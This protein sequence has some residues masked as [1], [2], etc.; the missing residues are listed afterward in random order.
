MKSS[1]QI[2]GTSLSNPVNYYHSVPSSAV[3]SIAQQDNDEKLDSSSVKINKTAS[4]KN[5][6]ALKV[7]TMTVGKFGNLGPVNTIPAITTSTNIRAKTFT[8]NTGLPNN[9]PVI[10]AMTEFRPIFSGDKK[11]GNKNTRNELGKILSLKETAGLANAK[12]AIALLSQSEDTKEVIKNSKSSLEI[13]AQAEDRNIVQLMKEMDGALKSLEVTGHKLNVKDYFSNSVKSIYDILIKGG[14][15][16]KEISTFTETKMWQ[17][18]LVEVKKTL[19]THTPDLLQQKFVRTPS[20]DEKSPF[21][22]SDVD[23][24]PVNA[25]NLW[26]NTSYD[27][28]PTLAMVTNKQ[29]VVSNNVNLQNFQAKQFINFSNANAPIKISK[30]S[31]TA[32][33]GQNAKNILPKFQGKESGSPSVFGN[34]VLAPHASSGRDISILAHILRREATYSSVLLDDDSAAAISKRFGYTIDPEGNNMKVWDYMIGKF[35]KSVLDFIETPQ[36]NGNSLVSLSQRVVK[37][38]QDSYNVLTFE[39]N[40]IENQN[41]TPGTFYYVD[42]AINT[43]D[44]ANFDTT[45]LEKLISDVSN[46]HNTTTMMLEMLGVESATE[47]NDSGGSVENYK[48]KKTNETISLEALVKSL[49]VVT[50]TYE[51]FMEVSGDRIKSLLSTASQDADLATNRLAA[52]ICKTAVQPTNL[53]KSKSQALKAN[54]FLWLLNTAMQQSE[55]V[56]NSETI[57]TYRASIA[58]LLTYDQSLK[59]K[60]PQL[61]NSAYSD[62]RVYATSVRNISDAATQVDFGVNLFE[63]NGFSLYQELFFAKLEQ[64]LNEEQQAAEAERKKAFQEYQDSITNRIFKLE[65]KKGLWNVIVTLL[66][67]VYDSPNIFTQKDVTAY[68][69][70]NRIAYLY[71]YFDLILRIIAAQ[72]PENLTGVYT[73][74]IDKPID[75]KVLLLPETAAAAN[76]ILN[77]FGYSI[78]SKIVEEGITQDRAPLE[79]QETG[80][81]LEKTSESQLNSYFDQTKMKSFFSVRRLT[82]AV[83]YADAEESFAIREVAI[84][85]SYLAQL[86]KTLI[87]Y[88]SYLTHNFEKYLA[89]IKNLFASDS[90]LNQNQKNALTNLSV[91]EEQLKL[92]RYVMSEYIDRLKTDDATSKLNSL[93]VFKAFPEGYY[94]FL[95]MS[96]LDHISY[97]ILSPYFSGNEFLNTKGNNKKIVSVGI[98][99]KMIKTLNTMVREGNEVSKGLQQGIIRLKVWKLDKLHP[100]VVYTPVS[101]LFETNRFP[102]RSMGN[103]NYQ[104]IS[105]ATSNL[106]E[107]PTKVLY[108]DGKIVLN[109][110]FREAFPA[111]DYGNY[112]KPQEKLE[113]YSN[114]AM[115]FLLEQYLK[116]FTDLNF[117]ETRYHNFSALSP[118]MKAVKSQYDKYVS[119]VLK[120]FKKSQAT[121]EPVPDNSKPSS[122]YKSSKP[123]QK[124]KILGSLSKAKTAVSVATQKVITQSTVD[125]LKKNKPKDKYVIPMDDTIEKFFENETFMT[126]MDDF[127]KRI[128]YPKKFDRV[129]NIIVDPDDFYVDVSMT[130]RDVIDALV[131]EKV[132][133]TVKSG[134]TGGYKHRD[135]T[136]EDAWLEEYFV[137]IEPFDY[138]PEYEV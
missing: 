113:I 104:A 53:Y 112:L 87:S 37:S 107:I 64:E 38:G 63:Q 72:T 7:P 102:T 44:G 49:Y 103:W 55:G 62:G 5:L 110:E 8:L 121:P 1:K 23:D 128:L 12:A 88:R 98:P 11:V 66:K 21:R 15:T 120:D 57:K 133:S 115:S 27:N 50:K 123:T 117:E 116:W 97:T 134:K 75:P 100:D 35:P 13:F 67:E 24:P 73:K 30:P 46:A 47:V 59:I 125:N 28:L 127:K 70:I 101:Y 99:Q 77:D 80:L 137:T 105:T 126:D 32:T 83:S 16:S 81:M 111:S 51:K 17:Q 122:G 43:P 52:V 25:K 91:S 36:G 41:I 135:T 96:E 9:E 26:I 60:N 40:F 69:G 119:S 131:S 136:Q 6:I 29:S 85:R 92:A 14:Y 118:E 19:M 79:I 20:D 3:K 33:V 124:S 94:D 106:T 108:P 130:E 22:L 138:F 89:D 56:G 114:H 71:S 45:R 58:L 34:E 31:T 18:A 132:L 54:L 74:V 68:S 90:S 65:A 2:S 82:N 10:V 42:S 76:D 95:S 78:D 129:F 48:R 93:P 39:N 61:I 86:N 109:R 4:K 84:F